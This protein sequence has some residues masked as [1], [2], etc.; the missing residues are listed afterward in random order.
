MVKKKR[1]RRTE[2]KEKT[3]QG[4]TVWKRR[5][6]VQKLHGQVKMIERPSPRR[7][8]LFPLVSFSFSFIS[9]WDYLARYWYT[10]AF[11]YTYINNT[12]SAE[13]L[14]SPLPLSLSLSLQ[15]FETCSVLRDKSHRQRGRRESILRSYASRGST[16]VH[17]TQLPGVCPKMENAG[18]FSGERET[19][20]RRNGEG[21]G[22]RERERERREGKK[23][24]G[25]GGRVGT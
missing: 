6:I 16:P 15:N 7:S 22:G 3:K 19:E 25:R 1:R 10:L 11:L 23:V 14:S 2:G 18:L 17:R 12:A 13:R 5:I 24:K 21:Q 4:C 20:K 8:R 9:R